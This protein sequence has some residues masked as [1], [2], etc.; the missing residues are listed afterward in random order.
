MTAEKIA[1]GVLFSTSSPS[2]IIVPPYV[3][4]VDGVS[5]NTCKYR[6][7]DIE[8]SSDVVIDEDDKFS[9]TVPGMTNWSVVLAAI[10]I[11][12]GLGLLVIGVKEIK[13]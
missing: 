8:D 4:V 3:I 11:V 12:V 1:N 2:M 6:D 9:Y 5:S 7:D 10:A 13:S